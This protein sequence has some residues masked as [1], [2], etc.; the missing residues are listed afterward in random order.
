MVFWLGEWFAF[1][2]FLQSIANNLFLR[3][4]TSDELTQDEDMEGGEPI[5]MIDMDTSKNRKKDKP[6]GSNGNDLTQVSEA[7]ASTHKLNGTD[8][9]LITEEPPDKP[10]DDTFIRELTKNWISAGKA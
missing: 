10:S 1:K 2:F 4:K 3:K 9:T 7:Y 6:Q 5:E 8:N